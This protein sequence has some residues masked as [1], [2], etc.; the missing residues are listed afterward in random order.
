MPAWIVCPARADTA[1]QHG[2]PRAAVRGDASD[3][4]AAC[5]TL[6]PVLPDLSASG[7]PHEGT[8]CVPRDEKR[9]DATIHAVNHAEQ[10]GACALGVRGRRQR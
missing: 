1:G 7:T 3:S 10:Q 5:Q 4:G 6:S 8:M 2:L 9:L